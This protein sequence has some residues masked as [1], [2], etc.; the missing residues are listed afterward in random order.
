M[1]KLHRK[2]NRKPTL[3]EDGEWKISLLNS[4]DGM[5]NSMK[6]NMGPDG[7]DLEKGLEKLKSMNPDSVKMLMEKGK[8]MMDSMMKKQ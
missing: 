8:Q 7:H 4:G 6:G 2:A 3:K 5:F 1:Q